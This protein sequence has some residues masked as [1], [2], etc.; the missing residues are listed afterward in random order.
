MA[1]E[2][3]QYVR[4]T[5]GNRYA[6]LTRVCESDSCRPGLLPVLHLDP[7]DVHWF[8]YEITRLAQLSDS[9]VSTRTLYGNTTNRLPFP[10]LP[11][12]VPPGST[13]AVCSVCEGPFLVE[14]PIQAWI[15]LRVATDVL[16]LVVHSCSPE[17][18]EALPTPPTNYVQHACVGGQN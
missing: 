6:G 12:E 1:S 18:L 17:C 16:P 11:A 8:P 5:Y 13:P 10:K 15:S 3:R 14:G 7:Q 9:T 2:I 4:V